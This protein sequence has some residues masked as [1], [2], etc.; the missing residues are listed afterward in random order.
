MIP[1]VAPLVGWAAKSA[2][3]QSPIG[4]LIKSVPKPVWKWLAIALVVA[5]VVWRGLAWHA[6]KVDQLKKDSFAAGRQ[7]AAADMVALRDQLNRAHAQDVARMRSQNDAKLRDVGRDADALRL[8][9]PGRAACS[10]V[11]PGG[12][13]GSQQ[14]GGQASAP[15]SQLPDAGGAELIALRFDAATDLGE[16]H[17]ALRVEVLGWREWHAHFV[18][19]WSDYAAKVA[20]ATEPSK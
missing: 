19:L 17:D 1:F 13:G 4:R 20:K 7:S 18:K 15:V 9:G 2:L 16:S 12:A 8:R 10:A 5:L 6:G 3:M 11:V 14:A